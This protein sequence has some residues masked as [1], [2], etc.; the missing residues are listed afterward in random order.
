MAE[1][2]NDV[3]ES[4]T[5]RASSQQFGFGFGR[6]G[7]R[8]P[9]QQNQSTQSTGEGGI[10]GLPEINVV[11]DER[12]NSVIVTTTS[13]DTLGSLAQTYLNS[14]NNAWKIARYNLIETVTPG[15]Q[16]VIENGI[17]QNSWNGLRILYT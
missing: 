16:I 9:Q 6:G 1:E 14:E 7:F 4:S 8:G 2:L 13:Q 3:F 11:A 10:L 12:T 5:S 17:F 15:R